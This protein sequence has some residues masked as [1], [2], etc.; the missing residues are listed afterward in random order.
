[1]WARFMPAGGNGQRE[2]GKTK[3]LKAWASRNHCQGEKGLGSQEEKQESA[4]KVAKG[5]A[6]YS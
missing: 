3:A 5:Q 1:M 6:I 2:Q 4:E